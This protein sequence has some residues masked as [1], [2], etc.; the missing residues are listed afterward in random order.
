MKYIPSKKDVTRKFNFQN[1]L[2][3]LVTGGPHI[4][5]GAHCQKANHVTRGLE[6]SV[7]P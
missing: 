5:I 1:D 7:L 6:P 2:T 3:I 4:T